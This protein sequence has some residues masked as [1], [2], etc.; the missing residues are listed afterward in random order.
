MSLPWSIAL[1]KPAR[2]TGCAVGLPVFLS[3]E[4]PRASRGRLWVPPSSVPHSLTTGRR[5]TA[6]MPLTGD[7]R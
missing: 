2:P 4:P 7:A 5:T 1:L 6:F 3:C